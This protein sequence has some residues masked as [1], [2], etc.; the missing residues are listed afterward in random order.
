MENLKQQQNIDLESVKRVAE[1][2]ERM[3]AK[4]A[5]AQEEDE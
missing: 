2:V 1:K 5:F 4:A 3:L